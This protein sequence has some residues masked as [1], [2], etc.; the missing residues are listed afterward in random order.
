MILMFVG[1]ISCQALIN[2]LSDWEV[3]WWKPDLI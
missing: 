2:Y 3:D 1:G